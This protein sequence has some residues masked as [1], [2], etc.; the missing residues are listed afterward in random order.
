MQKKN[1]KREHQTW[2]GLY[3]RVTKTKKEKLESTERK[4]RKDLRREEF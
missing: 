4:H 3:P 1:Q 2:R